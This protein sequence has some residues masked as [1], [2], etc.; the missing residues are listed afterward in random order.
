MIVQV[1]QTSAGARDLSPA[2]STGLSLFL[3]GPHRVAP[4]GRNPHRRSD[5]SGCATFRLLQIR[6]PICP[7]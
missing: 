3:P 6:T 2:H 1:I 4:I 5:L 7:L